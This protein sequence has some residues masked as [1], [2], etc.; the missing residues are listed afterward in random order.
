M[1]ASTLMPL[2]RYRD[3]GVASEWLCAAFGFETHFAAKAPD[4]QVFYA[5]LRF[6]DSMIMLGSVGEPGLDALMSQP[7]DAGTAQTQ[8]CYVVVPGTEAHYERAK[9]AGAEI[10]LDLKQDDKGGRGYS[11]RDPEGHVWNF[12]SYDPWTA[13]AVPAARAQRRPP[14]K[15]G[16]RGLRAAI[17]LTLVGS[18]ISG[19]LL[20]GQLG[21]S[22]TAIDIRESLLRGRASPAPD[23]QSPPSNST[24]A[25]GTIARQSEAA[26][27]EELSRTHAAM[28]A[29]KR[30][31]ERERHARQQAI[32]S[33]AAAK[34]QAAATTTD[35]TRRL[36]AETERANVEREQRSASQ[37]GE[38]AAKSLEQ[39]LARAMSERERAVEAAREAADALTRER[40]AKEAALQA[41]AAA[42]DE[43][44][45]ERA[46]KE[47]ALKAAGEAEGKIATAEA[48]NGTLRRDTEALRERL[49]RLEQQKTAAT[50]PAPPKDAA[51]K[52]AQRPL[53]RIRN[54]SSARKKLKKQTAQPQV[55]PYS[56]W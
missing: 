39:D 1:A 14:A 24:M 23:A 9:R 46:A 16:S 5:E 21:G 27:K 6:A 52:P 53:K 35:L 40:H 10:V 47:Q 28:N 36:Q 54:L 34:S 56:S 11:C 30:D 15:P 33:A 7:D 18:V 44:T 41:V 26:V 42:Q 38:A 49:A 50:K 45:R 51:A 2:M 48:A 43:I 37:S 8:S 4:G 13:Q 20:Y 55:W 32:D 29:L 19:W 3:V 22:L 31:L 25:T 17:A 12:G